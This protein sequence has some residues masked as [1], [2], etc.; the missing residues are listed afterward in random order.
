VIINVVNSTD[1]TF[2]DARKSPEANLILD[3][4]VPAGAL[5]RLEASSALEVNGTTWT[6]VATN[7]SGSNH[8]QFILP[9]PSIYTRRFYRMRILR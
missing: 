8:I 9:D 1:L 3:A 7:T 2:I 6:P 4:F 5:V